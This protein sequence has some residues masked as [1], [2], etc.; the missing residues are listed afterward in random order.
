MLTSNFKPTG[1]HSKK[2]SLWPG[3]HCDVQ[4]KWNQPGGIF[5]EK[6]HKGTDATYSP[7]SMPH[8]DVIYAFAPKLPTWVVKELCLFMMHI[9]ISYT[10]SA[11]RSMTYTDRMTDENSFRDAPHS[12]GVLFAINFPQSQVGQRT[13]YSSGSS[14]PIMQCMCHCMVMTNF[15]CRICC[16]MLVS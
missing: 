16:G 9:S 1:S 7:Q 6:R 12:H 14:P 8:V 10:D 5:E 3:G 13:L 2:H 15:S 4:P 11:G